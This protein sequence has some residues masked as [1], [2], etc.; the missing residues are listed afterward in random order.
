MPATFKK[1]EAFELEAEDEE[2]LQGIRWMSKKQ[3]KKMKA[4]ENYEQN[5]IDGK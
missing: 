3:I 1:M 2:C 4:A 5:V